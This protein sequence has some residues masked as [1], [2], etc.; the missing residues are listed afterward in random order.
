MSN[1]L[2]VLIVSSSPTFSKLCAAKLLR[3]QWQAFATRISFIRHSW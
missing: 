1:F 2:I 3:F